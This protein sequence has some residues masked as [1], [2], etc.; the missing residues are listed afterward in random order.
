M[1]EVERSLGFGLGNAA[2]RGDGVGLATST[3][4]PI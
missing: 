4:L 3:A 2:L 1:G